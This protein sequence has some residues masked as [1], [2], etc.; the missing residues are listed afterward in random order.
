MP[1]WPRPYTIFVA[2]LTPT[3]FAQW[4]DDLVQDI[5]SLD[6]GGFNVRLGVVRF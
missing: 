6:R 1:L 5:L 2:E 3:G 4:A